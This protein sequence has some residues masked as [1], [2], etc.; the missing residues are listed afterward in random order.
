MVINNYKWNTKLDIVY[1]KKVHEMGLMD[2]TEK[3]G[4]FLSTT[5]Q[6]Y[7]HKKNKPHNHPSW[8]NHDHTC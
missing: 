3:L 2:I 8:D 5:T 6:Q 7:L 1:V 4:K